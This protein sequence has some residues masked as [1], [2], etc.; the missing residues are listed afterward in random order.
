[1]SFPEHKVL[2]QRPGVAVRAC[3]VQRPSFV[4]AC[5]KPC[6]GYNVQVERANGKSV[7]HHAHDVGAQMHC[8]RGYMHSV[9]RPRT[10]CGPVRDAGAGQ[11]DS[12]C[13]RT[14]G[15][16]V[17]ASQSV[18]CCAHHIGLKVPTR[19]SP[20]AGR[21]DRLR[22]RSGAGARRGRVKDSR[23]TQP[24]RND[25]LLLMRANYRNVRWSSARLVCAVA[26]ARVAHGQEARGGSRADCALLNA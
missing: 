22:C 12:A 10:A 4:V 24:R 14:R 25:I 19:V 6:V 2:I 8:V 23:G 11:A 18:A 20:R 16:C 13:L 7:P 26:V 5:E 3:G 9:A 15:A 17:F 1:V 21:G